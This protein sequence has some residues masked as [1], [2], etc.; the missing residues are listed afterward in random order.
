[1]LSRLPSPPQ[2]LRSRETRQ[3]A[4]NSKLQRSTKLQA[5]KPT[6]A[7]SAPASGGLVFCDLELLWSPHALRAPRSM[8]ILFS[9]E[10]ALG[11]WRFAQSGGSK[12]ASKRRGK[13]RSAAR[14]VDRSS[15]GSGAPIHRDRFS[16]RLSDRERMREIFWC[17]PRR[18][19]SRRP[20]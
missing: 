6:C 18:G 12:T 1:M 16:R 19:E 20:G 4:P 13:A 15:V 9:E 2:S 7:P 14:R 5:Q 10:L 11:T 3:Q 17:V 8:K